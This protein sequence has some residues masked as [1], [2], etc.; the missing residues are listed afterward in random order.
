MPFNFTKL[1]QPAALSAGLL[2]ANFGATQ[3]AETGIYGN[4]VAERIQGQKVSAKV[5]STLDIAKD[6]NITGNA[7]CNQYMGGMEIKGETIKVQP[8]GS[9]RMAC[10]PA[11]M[12]Q[13]SK[14]HA[15][16][17]TVTSWKISKGKLILTD[18]KKREVLRLKRA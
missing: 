11:Q 15:A 6:G 14:F 7:G 1:I 12:Q 3:A 9:T 10:P 4:W 18:A 13:D 8:A 2:L 17:G 5:Q 16:L